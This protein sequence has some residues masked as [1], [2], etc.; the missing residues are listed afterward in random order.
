MSLLESLSPKKGS[1]Y[2]SKRIGRG[3]GSGKGGTAGKGHKGQKARAGGSIIRGFEG[4]QTPMARRLP[5]FGF[6]NVQFTTR[7]EVVNLKQLNQFKG[8]VDI[9]VLKKSGLIKNGPVKILGEGELSASVNVSA[10]KFSE[11]AKKAIEEKGGSVSVIS[12]Q[13]E[14]WVRPSKKKK[15][16]A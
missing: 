13:A 9:E 5:K 11:S 7:F 3:D 6:S 10:N 8:D 1:H 12:F 2:K 14:K 15:V 4:G 16:E